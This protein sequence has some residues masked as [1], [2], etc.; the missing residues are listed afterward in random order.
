MIE[1]LRA[2]AALREMDEIQEA[3][4]ST[5]FGRLL[6]IIVR[7]VTENPSPDTGPNS[8][9]AEAV[10]SDGLEVASHSILAVGIEK[11]LKPFHWTGGDGQ[12]ILDFEIAH[13]NIFT[14]D[15][16]R[17]IMADHVLTLG[18]RVIRQFESVNKN[19]RDLR[20][21]ETTE[22]EDSSIDRL[23]EQIEA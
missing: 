19:L 15:R 11:Q 14:S 17:R 4:E 20:I 2:K 1:A 16:R 7:E 8:L 21:S 22:L 9:R 18:G 6:G 13:C 23:A 5:S 12:K 10:I 3:A